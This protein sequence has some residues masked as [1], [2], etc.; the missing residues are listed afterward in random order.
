MEPTL[1]AP[2]AIVTTA[3]AMLVNMTASTAPQTRTAADTPPATT[4]E[5]VTRPHESGALSRGAPGG[6]HRLRRTIVEGRRGRGWEN[7]GFGCDSE[8]A[9]RRAADRPGQ[10]GTA[11][12]GA[13]AARP[14]YPRLA[15]RA[16]L[17]LPHDARYRR[18]VRRERRD[19][20]RA[21]R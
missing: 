15:G 21:E 1:A 18:E 3:F 14:R 8:R 7:P 12:S 2:V 5:S 6:R 17:R 10:C 20:F 9:E 19:R 11:G 13:A 16:A 4:M